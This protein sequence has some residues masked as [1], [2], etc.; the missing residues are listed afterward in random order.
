MPRGRRASASFLA[1]RVVGV[2]TCAYQCALW[3]VDLAL[4]RRRHIDLIAATGTAHRDRR[5]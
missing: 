2:R 4:G 3:R 5:S 1:Q